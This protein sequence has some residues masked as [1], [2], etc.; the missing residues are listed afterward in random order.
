ML[1][2]GCQAAE[3]EGEMEETP[4]TEEEHDHDDSEG[5]E[6]HVHTNDE[7]IPEDVEIEGV[8]HHYH[9]GDQIELT[10]KVQM[11]NEHD[12]WHWY[13]RD[14][15]EEEW[16]MAT[17]QTGSNFVGEATVDGQEI[18]A[19]LYDEQHEPV[20]Q[21]AP[22]VIEIDDH[23]HDHSHAHD[24][25]TQQIYNGYFEDSQIEDRELSDWEG[26]WQSVYPYLLDGTLDEVFTHK[27][28]DGG[29]KTAAEYKEYYRIGYETVV[30]QIMIEGQNVT[31]VENGESNSGE[32]V[33]DGYEILTYERGNRGVRFIFKLDEESDQLPTYI[34]F[35]DHII[36]PTK[37]HHFHLYWGDDREALLEEVTHWPT[38][39]PSNLS[40]DEIVHEMIAH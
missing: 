4:G 14:S 18:K 31:F 15:S 27:E 38:Y 1:L 30:E 7:E 24:E 25:E 32:Y 39:Y 16:E 33:Y 5:E 35:S 19:V 36:F 23:G 12:D 11:D 37:S 22:V 40:A 3:T 26:D 13:V 29:D 17:G 6:E 2:V 20:V 10:A 21:S 9:T 34:Q 8:A 28:E